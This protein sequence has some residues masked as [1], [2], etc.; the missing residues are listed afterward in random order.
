M[1]PHCPPHRPNKYHGTVACASKNNSFVNL[2]TVDHC[3]PAAVS[4]FPLPG[5]LGQDNF[6]DQRGF[7]PWH[8]SGERHATSAGDR[9]LRATRFGRLTVQTNHFLFRIVSTTSG[10]RTSFSS[11]GVVFLQGVEIYGR[12]IIDLSVSF[13]LLSVR[14]LRF[15]MRLESKK[16]IDDRERENNRYWMFQC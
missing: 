12:G 4:A 5:S 13:F 10:A 8:R 14:Q 1:H 16:W 15:I 9:S 6:E 11:I 3:Q 7:W 2:L